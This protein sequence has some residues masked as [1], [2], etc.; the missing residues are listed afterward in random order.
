MGAACGRR[1]MK[2]RRARIFFLGISQERVALPRFAPEKKKGKGASLFDS[3]PAN[4]KGGSEPRSALGRR[5]RVRK[6]K[7]RTKAFEREGSPA[8]ESRTPRRG[9]SGAQSVK[10][11]PPPDAPAGEEE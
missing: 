6:K 5:R 11:L 10:S 7:K 2:Q 8:R 9:R 3:R 4:S 1:E